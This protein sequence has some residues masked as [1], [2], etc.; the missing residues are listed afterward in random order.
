MDLL[1]F[2][3]SQNIRYLET[4]KLTILIEL[5]VEIF[6]AQTLATVLASAQG[7]I[8]ATVQSSYFLEENPINSSN[9]EATYGFMQSCS[10]LLPWCCKLRFTQ[11][12]HHMWWKF[13]FTWHFH[14]TWWKF[15]FT[16]HF[17]YTWWKFRLT[18]HFH[19]RL[20]RH[21]HHRFTRHFHHRFT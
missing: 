21:F 17:H 18:R 15:R 14:H 8:L 3:C 9:K 5:H 12:L 19:H 11:H 10:V 6:K 20:T 13:R 7:C 1:E 16:R 2:Q 4:K